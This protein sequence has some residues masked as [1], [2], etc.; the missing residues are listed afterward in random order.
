MEN[1]SLDYSLNWDS[2]PSEVIASEDEVHVWRVPLNDSR[3]TELRSMLGPDECA[4]ADRFHFDRDRNHFIVARTSLRT[5]LGAYIKKNP[6]ELS[7]SYS[8]YGKP[9]L[10]GEPA[11]NGLSF[12]LSHANELA[13]I[14]VTRNRAIGVDIE[15]IR[16]EF[17]S[18]E[19][20]ERFFSRLEV[21]ELRALPA[22]RQ[23]E[24][25]FNC[26]TRKEAYIKARGEGM[27]LP[28]N[29]FNVSLAPGSDA[30][31]LGNL[32][33]AAEVLRWSLRE[34]HPGTGYRAAV[35]VEG[36]GWKLK[37]WQSSGT[38]FSL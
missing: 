20:A 25:F 26:W 31:L 36:H 32:R 2:P 10:F 1:K 37:C 23:S 24:A 8:R 21:S 30:A 9:S 5:I 33:D 17:A 27:S 4:R 13:L 3:I 18:E 19:I 15:F 29:Q 6:A 12:N 38:D 28:L 14:A 35:A 11:A 7:F 22:D 34:L 16:P